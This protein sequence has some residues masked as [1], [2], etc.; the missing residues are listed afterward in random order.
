MQAPCYHRTMALLGALSLALASSTWTLV[1]GGDL[2]LNGLPASRDPLAG[3]G[4][5]L[6]EAD[7]AIVNLEIPLTRATRTTALKSA[8]ELRARTQFVLKAD[9]GHARH[10][11]AAGI[12][13]VSLA[14]N[15]A[16]DY[17]AEGLREMLG[18]LRQAGIGWAGAG[19]TRAAAEEAAV[20]TARDGTRLGLLSYLAFVGS[21]AMAKC[22]PAGAASPGIAI[23]DFGGRVD[24]RA[25]RRLREAIEKARRRCD[26]VVV[27][28]HWG[29]ERQ[30]R[31]RAYQVELGRAWIEAG[32][33]A[34]LGSHPHVLQGSEIYR[35]RPILYSMGNLVAS[36]PGDT[37][38]YRL[39]FRGSRF[40]RLEVLPARI[41]GGVVRVRPSERASEAI[42]RLDA[43]VARDYPS[44]LSSRP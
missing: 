25:R 24:E 43:L 14:N 40:T 28:L 12:D 3:V 10:L 7:A 39:H 27:A 33:D 9:P 32:A 6:R 2:M 29:I 5:L 4:E 26:V 19:E 23:L 1:A 11:A 34:V 36:K 38:L 22:G 35:G 42:R 41:E 20:V 16:M 18:H 21:G 37:A 31:P 44:P 13:L 15:H 8:A 17:R 30:T